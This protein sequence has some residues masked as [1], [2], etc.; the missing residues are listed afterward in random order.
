MTLYLLP[1]SSAALR[2]EDGG[3]PELGAGL[4]GPETP[5]ALPGGRGPSAELRAAPGGPAGAEEA[6][7][8]GPLGGALQEAQR[9]HGEQDHAAAAQDRPAGE[10]RVVHRRSS[11]SKTLSRPLLL[12]SRRNR[13]R[14]GTDIIRWWLITWQT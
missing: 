10:E 8:R 3:D 6:E 1:V 9:G 14:R 13:K 5:P 2:A 12:N 4:A 7:G 11:S